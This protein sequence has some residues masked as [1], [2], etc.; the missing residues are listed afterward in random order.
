MSAFASY[1][2][3]DESHPTGGSQESEGDDEERTRV[4]LPG[5]QQLALERREVPEHVAHV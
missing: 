3:M 1:A 5:P 4:G 2:P